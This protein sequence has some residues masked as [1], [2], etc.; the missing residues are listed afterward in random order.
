MRT[1]ETR[2]PTLNFLLD[3]K[4]SPYHPEVV[5]VLITEVEKEAKETKEVIVCG[6]YG[7]EANAF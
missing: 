6:G 2:S 7:G 4:E 5:I 3:S 1:I